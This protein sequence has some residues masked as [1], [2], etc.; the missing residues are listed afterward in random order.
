[1]SDRPKLY[2]VKEY[3]D[4]YRVD[5]RTVYRWVR[6]G[7]VTVVQRGPRKCLRILDDDFLVFTGAQ[8]TSATN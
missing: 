7:A 5:Q 3:A 2:T 8:A 6:E 1:M 4:L